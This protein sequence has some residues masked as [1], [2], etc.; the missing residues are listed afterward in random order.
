RELKDTLEG[1]MS[2]MMYSYGVQY[3]V[4]V[5]DDASTDK[6]EEVLADASNLIYIRNEKNLG[7]VQSCN[8]GAEGAKGKFLLFLNNDTQVTENWLRPLVDNFTE[9]QA[10]GAVGPKI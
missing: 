5:V 6:T 3:A 1:M 8:R 10:V 4:I 7:F 9:Y 2:V